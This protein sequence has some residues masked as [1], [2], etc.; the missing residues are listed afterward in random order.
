VPSRCWQPARSWAAL[1]DDEAA[2]GHYLAALDHAYDQDDP[3]AATDA[4]ERLDELRGVAEAD[5]LGWDR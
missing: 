3:V 2:E 5:D 1:G 4:I